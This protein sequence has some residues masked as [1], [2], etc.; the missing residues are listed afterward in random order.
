[1]LHGDCREVLKS[2]RDASV[3]MICTSPPYYRLRDAGDSAQIGMEKTPEE[4]LSALVTAF[5]EAL[6]LLTADGVMFLNLGDT[7]INK[8]RLMIPA[9]AALA[10]EGDGWIIAD[11]IVWH[12]PRTTPGRIKCRTVPAHEMI[13]LLAKSEDYYFDAEAIKEPALY[14]GYVRKASHCFRDLGDVNPDPKRR[15]PQKADRVITVGET[16]YKRS[17]WSISPPPYIDGHFS[18]M[19]PELAECCILAGSRKGDVVLDP[20]FGAGTTGLVADRLERDCVG[21]ELVARNNVRAVSRITSDA[22]L[23]AEIASA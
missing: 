22:G 8:R 6:R 2:L 20:F 11:Q 10:M 4:Y 3:Q 19:P 9:R 7:T 1:V 16:R 23:F 12:K 14:A 13:Y 15:R 18:T 21:I 5:R 17:V